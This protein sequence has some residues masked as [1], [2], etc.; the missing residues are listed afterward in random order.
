[1]F[2]IY[3]GR[4][5]FYQWDLNQ[6]LVVFDDSITEVHFCNKTDDCAL[7]CEVYKDGTL[8]LVNVPNILLQDNWTIRA[9][10]VAADHTEHEARFKVLSRSKPA[11]YVYTET[12]CKTFEL[13][14]QRMDELEN[15]FTEE[16][17]TKAVTEYLEENPVEAG[18]KIYYAQVVPNG[19]NPTEDGVRFIDA[20]AE[21]Q[22][23]VLNGETVIASVMGG[24]YANL[25]MH[26]KDNILAF[27]CFADGTNIMVV[28]TADNNA[29]VHTIGY[30]TDEVFI[31]AVDR[32]P[33][34]VSELEND[35]N[36]VNI[37]QTYMA[38]NMKQEETNISTFIN[39]SGYTTAAQVKAIVDSELGVIE[40]GTY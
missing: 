17:I 13:L 26:E 23:R 8:N 25:V 31:N 5:N 10:G 15:S 7:V 21:L 9:Y 12:E 38:I 18:S 1:M 36:Y 6:K 16:G 35:A 3:D 34:K 37:N 32:F 2:K 11:D 33:K 28:L 4:T 20:F 27:S 14:E 40:N 22:E 39:D 19:D 29:L 24:I 30:V